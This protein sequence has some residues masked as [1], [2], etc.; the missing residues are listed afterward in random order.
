MQNTI[1][2]L[3]RNK[4]LAEGTK[5]ANSPAMAMSLNAELMQLGFTFTADALEA[6]MNSSEAH[7]GR[8]YFDIIPELK[9][10]MGANRKFKAFW[11]NFP[12]DVMNASDFKLWSAATAHYWSLGHW[13]PKDIDD[14]S[15]GY[16]FEHTVFTP[17]SLGKEEDLQEIFTN[18]LSANGS[19][20]PEHKETLVFFFKNYDNLKFPETITFKE[21]R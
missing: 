6:L 20:T 5:G 16:A 14:C 17:V 15:R 2:F 9:N 18:L 19:I 8:L 10:R 12:Q 7:I 11:K 4:V 1:L 3:K 21:N 13:E